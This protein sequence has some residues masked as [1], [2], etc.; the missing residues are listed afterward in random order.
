MAPGASC[1]APQNGCRPAQ[2][3]SPAHPCC[4]RLHPHHP[5][6][7]TAAAMQMAL[8]Q[9]RVPAATA[10]AAGTRLA[11]PCLPPR[12]R[13]ARRHRAAIA[14]AAT[15]AAPAKPAAKVDG[16]GHTALLHSLG[17]VGDVAPVHLPWLLRLAHIKSRITGGDS[18][19]ALQ[20]SARGLLMWKVRGAV[21]VPLPVPGPVAAGTGRHAEGGTA[22][23][24][25]RQRRAGRPARP[26]NSPSATLQAAL[27]RGLVLDDFTIQQLIDERDSPVAGQAVEELRWPEEPLRGVMVRSFSTLGA[28]R[29]AAL[30][31][32]AL[33]CAVLGTCVAVHLATLQH[34]V[35]PTRLPARHHC[36]PQ[37]WRGLLKSTPRCW[38]R[39]CARYW[40]CCASTT[41]RVGAGTTGDGR[42]A[43]MPALGRAP[44]RRVS[45]ARAPPR[46]S[47]ACATAPAA[48]Q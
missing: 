5:A 22:A 18:N 27:E 31:H 45:P 24:A 23:A 16:G 11:A 41:R 38:T 8:Q 6:Q 13:A 40:R 2:R 30:R 34:A 48:P 7:S 25:R 19:L 1:R 15:A 47:L 21:P 14:T 42:H 33:R 4:R 20:E 46:G 29:C 12:A 9:A 44:Q 39:C 17:E 3:P 36:A 32:A 28:L 35:A 37:A 26:C 43:V 10:A